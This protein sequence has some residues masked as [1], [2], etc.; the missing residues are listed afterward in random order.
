MNSDNPQSKTQLRLGRRDR[1]FLTVPAKDRSAQPTSHE[2]E[3]A[4]ENLLFEGLDNSPAQKDALGDG[5]GCVKE[6]P[7]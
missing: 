4:L 5:R 6:G 7:F 1:P 3:E 2:P